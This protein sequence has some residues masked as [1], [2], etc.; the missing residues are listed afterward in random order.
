MGHVASVNLKFFCC[1]NRLKFLLA[2]IIELNISMDDST[3]QTYQGRKFHD[4][5]VLDT[6]YVEATVLVQQ[7]AYVLDRYEFE[8]IVRWE[9]NASKF[10][11]LFSGAAV[12]WVVTVITKMVLNRIDPKINFDAWEV[13][14][15]VVAMAGKGICIIIDKYQ[16]DDRKEIVNKINNYFKH[17]RNA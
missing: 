14:A 15:I 5:V 7:V 8:K 2:K 17:K 10:G 16:I 1:S 6:S 4:P 13:I 9:S 12:A 3:Q 11:A